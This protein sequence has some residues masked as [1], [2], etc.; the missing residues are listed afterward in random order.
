M[1]WDIV[2]DDDDDDDDVDVD[3]VHDDDGDD[4]GD[5]D[6]D[7]M[8]IYIQINKYAMGMQWGIHLHNCEYTRVF[9]CS[10]YLHYNELL[11]IATQNMQNINTFDIW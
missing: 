10:I 1:G 3:V 2:D 8:Y 9:N 11:T 4:D 5:D 6:D 7:D